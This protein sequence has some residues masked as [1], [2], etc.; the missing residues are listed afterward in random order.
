MFAGPMISVSVAADGCWFAYSALDTWETLTERDQFC[1]IN[2][3]DGIEKMIIQIQL[4]G[5]EVRSSEQMAW[6][7]PI[8]APPE[9]VSLRHFQTIPRF[10]GN[11]LGSVVLEKV[12]DSSS[13]SLAFGTQ[14]YTVPALAV[15]YAT[16]GFGS[17]GTEESVESFGALDQ[18][19]VTSELL[20]AD[21]SE[22]LAAYLTSKGLALPEEAEYAVENYLGGDYSIVLS[23]VSNVS[24]F[25]AEAFKMPGTDAYSLGIGVEYPCE[26]IFFPLEMTSA[27]GTLEIPVTIQVLDHV[28]PEEHPSGGGLDYSCRYRVQDNY[29]PLSTTALWEYD[30]RLV[31]RINLT[32]NEEEFDYFFAEQIAANHGSLV[33]HSVDYT[34]ISF[35]G[36]AGRLTE[37][38]WLSDS[39]PVSVSTLH[40]IGDNPWLVVLAVFM[41]ASCFSSLVACLILFGWNGRLTL[42]FILLGASNL[43]SIVGY[44]FAYDILEPRLEREGIRTVGTRWRLMLLFSALFICQLGLVYFTFFY[45]PTVGM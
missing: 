32:V 26:E 16:F 37:D 20:A 22:A 8:P 7:F 19:G 31:S 6:L 14:L 27:Y 28:T 10:D 36:P 42:T 21:S 33:L 23:W 35:Y 2:Y 30:Y 5:P 43:L 17:G 29:G 41:V 15:Y 24:S 44:Y 34:V 39:Q 25:L 4:D 12:A 40:F 3:N 11:S 38:L 1:I 45:G 9:S 18:Y 13:W